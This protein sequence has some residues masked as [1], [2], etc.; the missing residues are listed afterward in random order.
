MPDGE[1]QGFDIAAAVESIGEGLDLGGE[2]EAATPE[3]GATS[4]T[5]AAQA[6]EKQPPAVEG[7]APPADPA[8]PAAPAPDASAYS[9]PEEFKHLFNEQGQLRTWR[10]EAAAQFATLPPAVQ[11]E[12]LKRE[13]DIFKG[14][15]GYKEAASFG[16]SMKQ[17]MAP[18][19]PILEHYKVE[20]AAQVAHIMKL[21]HT[22]AFGTQEQK[23]EILTQAIRDCNI[24]LSDWSPMSVQP[25]DPEVANLRKTVEQLQSQLTQSQRTQVETRR[26]EAEATVT[27]FASDPKNIYFDELASDIATLI[28]SG[29][30]T[31]VEGAYEKAMWMNPAVRAKELARQQAERAEAE[32][33]A[34]AEK[35]EAAKRATAA[36]VRSSP[37]AGSATTPVG[38]MEDTLKDTLATIRSR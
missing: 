19:M 35:A 18:Y 29:A 9:P 15:E 36:N 31:T 5:E 14:I 21:H 33:K 37:K 8:A 4:E 34:A 32:R 28:R 17:V 20:P 27:K 38:T 12:I 3:G 25:L 26:A 7:E 30:E 10:G 2:P 11:Q 22:M 24:D 13:T 1:E 6:A 23:R 16:N